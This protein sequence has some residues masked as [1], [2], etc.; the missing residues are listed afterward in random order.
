MGTML[1]E[2]LKAE[3]FDTTEPV[4]FYVPGMK[5]WDDERLLERSRKPQGEEGDE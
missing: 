5:G 3:Q 1:S 2:R 4:D